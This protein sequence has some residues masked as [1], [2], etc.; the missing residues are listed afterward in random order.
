VQEDIGRNF[1][2]W[3]GSSKSWQDQFTTQSKRHGFQGI[4]LLHSTHM[5]VS[6]RAMGD[7]MACYKP[8]AP[9]DQPEYNVA[10]LCSHPAWMRCNNSTIQSVPNTK[11]LLLER[12]IQSG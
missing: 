8:C 10:E 2:P 3:R 11:K 4:F 12:K 1:V 6:D 9:I 5:N 7:C